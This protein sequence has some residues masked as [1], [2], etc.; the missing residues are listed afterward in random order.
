MAGDREGRSRPQIEGPMS[1]DELLTSQTKSPVLATIE[2]VEGDQE[3]VKLTP[4]APSTG[5]LCESGI[6]VPKYTIDSVQRTGQ[7]HI[8]CG[9]VHDVVEVNFRDEATLRV[10]EVFRQLA[11]S[12]S[13]PTLGPLSPS[14][15]TFAGSQQQGH[16]FVGG[17]VAASRLLFRPR[18]P[19]RDPNCVADCTA[20]QA[21]CTSLCS[22]LGSNPLAVALCISACAAHG[23]YCRD[24]CYY[25][26]DQEFVA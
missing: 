16:N 18:R 21:T 7:R 9:R 4:W 17:R 6:K 12:A 25:L 24:N 8:C 10:S 15:A 26:F 14:L 20:S 22:L 19:E 1:V 5:C 3:L 11:A 23:Q 2:A 13:S